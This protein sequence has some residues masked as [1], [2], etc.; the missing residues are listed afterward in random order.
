MHGG[1]DRM[2]RWGTVLVAGASMEPA[3][4]DGDLLLVR[5]GAR[6]RPADVVVVQLPGVESLSVK[7]AVSQDGNGW[8]VEGDAPAVSVD[9]RQLG[10]L[11]GPAVHG[12]VVLRYWPRP[13]RLS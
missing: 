11:P 13:R 2:R 5:Y 9:S 4:R 1:K 6:V 3:L 8:W 10:P 12:R 7:R